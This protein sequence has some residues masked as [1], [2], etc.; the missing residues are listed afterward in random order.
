MIIG[1]INF[2]HYFNYLHS[3]FYSLHKNFYSGKVESLIKYNSGSLYNF[4]K[5]KKFNY[6]FKYLLLILLYKIII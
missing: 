3:L 6:D 1:K 2:K 4:N 5:I